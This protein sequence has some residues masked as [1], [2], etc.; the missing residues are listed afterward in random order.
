M[1]DISESQVVPAPQPVP[2]PGFIDELESVR[3]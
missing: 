1:F 2:V 3:N